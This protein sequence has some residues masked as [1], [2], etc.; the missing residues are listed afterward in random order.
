MREGWRCW[1]GWGS[2]GG[3]GGSAAAVHPAAGN[4]R[5]RFRLPRS[6]RMYRMEN[7]A[8]RR[9]SA[10]GTRWRLFARSFCVWSDEFYPLNAAALF[11]CHSLPANVACE[12]W[13][14]SYEALKEECKSVSIRR[15]KWMQMCYVIPYTGQR[16]PALQ[17][18]SVALKTLSLWGDLRSTPETPVIRCL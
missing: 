4:E 5:A 14:S 9:R 12:L 17:K 10:L 11:R 7:K 16:A 3:A 15:I 8:G 2:A 18:C 6:T 1:R 13:A